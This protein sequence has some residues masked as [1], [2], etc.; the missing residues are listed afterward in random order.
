ML[1]NHS[2]AKCSFDTVQRS[3][4]NEKSVCKTISLFNQS[5]HFE[6]LFCISW[7]IILFYYPTAENTVQIEDTVQITVQTYSDI[8][9][10]ENLFAVLVS[11][12]TQNRHTLPL[13]LVDLLTTAVG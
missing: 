8:R 12:C 2:L 9:K 11:V 6:Y 5:F 1:V 4:L 3:N 7:Y 13:S 10:V